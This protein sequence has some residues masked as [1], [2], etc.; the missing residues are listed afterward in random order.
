MKRN[1]LSGHW[2]NLYSEQQFKDKQTG[3]CNK[4][5]FQGVG[6]YYILEYSQ[7]CPRG[8]CYDDVVEVLS[9]SEVEDEVKDKMKDMANL[10]KES[11]C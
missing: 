11:R 10:L 2:V 3:R 7:P 4:G 8:C 6:K 9:A 5:Y 1:L